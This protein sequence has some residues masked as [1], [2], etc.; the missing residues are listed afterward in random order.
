[1][2]TP[3]MAALRRLTV[4]VVAAALAFGA[5]DLSSATAGGGVAQVAP[6]VVPT[7]ARPPELVWRTVRV[8]HVTRRYL[9]AVPHPAWWGGRTPPGRL[10]LI[11]A[12]HGMWQRPGSFAVGSGL[13][14]AASAN[15]VVLAVPASE[16]GIWNDGRLGPHGPQD[17]AF[18][19]ALK[20]QLVRSGLVA[21]N[22]VTVAGFSNGAGLAMAIASRHPHAVA[23][24]VAVSGELLAAP[25]SVRPTTAVTTVLVHGTTDH[26]Q[27]WNGRLR[28]SRDLAAYISVPATTAT[29]VKLLNAPRGP[30]LTRIVPTARTRA[31]ATRVTVFRWTGRRGT[32]V[33][34]YRLTAFGHSWP[35]SGRTWPD[36]F[37]HHAPIDGGAITVQTALTAHAS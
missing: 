2:R 31:S 8:G 32:T 13:L 18:F 16:Y 26:I 14:A 29:F 28:W 37:I 17:Q 10:P 30:E 4:T 22:R 23:A 6:P 24:V 21:V 1:M 5:V 9:L 33:T 35:V 19:L 15:G 36:Q 34:L 25:G 12:F 3:T 7:T 11:V 20:R 27:P